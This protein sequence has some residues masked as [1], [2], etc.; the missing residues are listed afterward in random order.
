M[1]TCAIAALWLVP[2]RAKEAPAMKA[3]IIVTP[4]GERLAM[5]SEADFLALLDAAEGGIDRKTLRRLRAAAA[6]GRTESVPGEMANRI[7][8]GEP[9]PPS[10]VSTGA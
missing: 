4:G 5:L 6:R 7:F 8:A 3:Q 1:R 9:P 10:G 2:R